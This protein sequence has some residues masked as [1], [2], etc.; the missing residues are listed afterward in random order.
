MPCRRAGFFDGRSRRARGGW[1]SN[2]LA[3]AKADSRINPQRSGE[4]RHAAEAKCLSRGIAGRST[5]GAYSARG[6]GGA[7][8]GHLLGAHTGRDGGNGG[9]KLKDIRATEAQLLLQTYE[10]NPIC[11]V[12]VSYTHLRA[13]ETGRNLVCRLLL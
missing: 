9:M 12:P 4:R 3:D 11:F 2:A 10:R 8:A 13:H 1:R 7:V 5:A 6:C